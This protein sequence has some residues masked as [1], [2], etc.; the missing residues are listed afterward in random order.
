M[1]FFRQHT[2]LTSPLGGES[3]FGVLTGLVVL[4]ELTL[5]EHGAVVSF[6]VA[7]ATDNAPAVAISAPRGWKTRTILKCGN[8]A[9]I[10]FCQRLALKD[11]E[12]DGRG[13]KK[14]YNLG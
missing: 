2:R 13:L 11:I 8:R 14:G 3:V 12:L 4:F 6:F 5:V 10:I 7:E 1:H 9:Y